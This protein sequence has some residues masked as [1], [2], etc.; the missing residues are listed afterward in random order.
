MDFANYK[1]IEVIEI[2]IRELNKKKLRSSKWD[3]DI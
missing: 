3:V 2:L 1:I